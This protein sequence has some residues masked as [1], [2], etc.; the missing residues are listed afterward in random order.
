[1]VEATVESLAR[2]GAERLRARPPSR[3]ARRRRSKSPTTIGAAWRSR[4]PGTT[5]V[6]EGGL[7]ANVGVT[8]TLNASGTVGTAQLGRARSRPPCRATATI[9]T[10]AAVRRG[11]DE[12]APRPTWCVTA[13]ERSNVEAD[14]RELL[15]SQALSAYEH[16]H[17]LGQHVAD[18]PSHRQRFGAA[19]RSP[20]GHHERDRRRRVGQRG[21]DADPEHQR[22]GAA[23][24]SST[25]TVTASLPGNGD[26]VAAA[27]VFGVGLD[28]RRHGRRGGDGASNDRMV[29]ADGR[30]FG[31][32]Q[33]LSALSTA[34]A[35]GQHL[36][37]DRSH[38]QRQ[39][40]VAIT[41]R[42]RRA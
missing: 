10:A 7:S 22:H 14:G 21:R 33:A 13:I 35:L 4:S 30:E 12:T 42:G 38:R 32:G 1:M 29:E 23:R 2:A 18:D 26:Y 39:R 37:D 25:C 40:S 11:L 15:G 17:G 5:G 6:T 36:A 31:S 28:R 9:R 20:S 34:T 19:W 3:P 27:A 41:S 16:G 24:P 8:L